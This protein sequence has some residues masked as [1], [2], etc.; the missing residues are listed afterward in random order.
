MAAV[1]PYRDFPVSSMWIR[2]G[3]M[4]SRGS[5]PPLPLHLLGR[6]GAGGGPEP[7]PPMSRT[8]GRASVTYTQGRYPWI[9]PWTQTRRLGSK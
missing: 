2:A 8:L 6:D 7:V 4:G 3:K 1:K 9:K 5:T